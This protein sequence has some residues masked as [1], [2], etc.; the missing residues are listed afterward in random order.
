MTKHVVQFSGGAGSWATARVVVDEIAGPDDEVVLLFADTLI[1][2]ADL[3]R[4]LEQASANLGLPITRVVEGRTPW[5][6]FNDK[7][8]IGN[9]RIDPCSYYLKRLPLREWME[10]HCDPEDTLVYLGIDFTEAHRYD[11]ARRYWEPWRVEAPLIDERPLDK[12]QQ[13]D[14][15]QREGI[16]LPRLYRMGFSHNNCGGFCIKAGMGHFKQLLE[17]LPEV[18]AHHEE[19][20]NAFRA[21]FNKDVS[22]LRDRSGGRVRS[23]PLE[24]LRR[25]VES[26]DPTIDAQDIGG[27]GCAVGDRELDAEVR[28]AMGED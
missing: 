15:L 7:K 27:C 21:R 6:V 8:Y 4:F 1:E 19:Q 17:E 13:L 18:Y 20:E 16:D 23:L 28:A 9:T 14:W 5:Q 24:V 22:I 11:K 12:Q 2:D 26:G 25:R 3:Y 10:Q